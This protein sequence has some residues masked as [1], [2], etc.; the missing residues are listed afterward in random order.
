MWRQILHFQHFPDFTQVSVLR[1]DM[2]RMHQEFHPGA[3][4]QRLWMFL[5]HCARMPGK[6]SSSSYRHGVLVCL[7]WTP[8]PPRHKSHTLAVTL[9][10]EDMWHAVPLLTS[11]TSRRSFFTGSCSLTF[12]SGGS[13]EAHT[14]CMIGIL[15]VVMLGTS[16]I[17]HT[18]MLF[19]V[20]LF[21]S[22][23][24]L[25][26]CCLCR[27]LKAWGHNFN[28][29]VHGMFH[30]I[31]ILY[32]CSVQSNTHMFQ[33]TGGFFLFSIWS[34]ISCPFQFLDLPLRGLRLGI[35]SNALEGIGCAGGGFGS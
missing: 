26:M 30:I 25:L 19:P 14:Y 18:A 33:K 31:I 29:L 34:S 20:V 23:A 22:H 17:L 16:S 6:S 9:P 28:F 32:L 11:H 35:I 13:K 12:R 3:I 1:K 15:N 21:E 4:M 2:W 8:R 5:F 27:Y 24:F 10:A 7:F